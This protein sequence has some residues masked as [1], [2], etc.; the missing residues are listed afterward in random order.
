MTP[1]P[2]TLVIA[3]ALAILL[4]QGAVAQEV[5]QDKPAA[6][7]PSVTPSNVT[8]DMLNGAASDAR[9]FLHT[10]GD[11]TQKRYHPAAQINTSNV[12]RLRPAWIFQTDVKNRWKPHPLS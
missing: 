10:N 3:G 9:N 2:T 7:N 1:I 6:A 4:T 5:R 12:Q 11:Y 8:Q